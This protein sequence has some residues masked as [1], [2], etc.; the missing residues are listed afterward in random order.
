MST[1]YRLCLYE[2]RKINI[3]SVN[4]PIWQEINQWAF[5]IPLDNK[6]FDSAEEAHN[7]RPPFIVQ[8]LEIQQIVNGVPQPNPVEFKPEPKPEPIIEPKTELKP[9]PKPQ[10]KQ[11]IPAWEKF[12]RK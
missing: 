4:R 11:N 3:G 8:R 5:T 12:L 6:L 1:Q 10:P 9:E 2:Q 7:R